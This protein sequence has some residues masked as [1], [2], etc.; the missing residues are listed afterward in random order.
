[1]SI[2]ATYIF[3]IASTVYGN[4]QGSYVYTIYNTKPL[5]PSQNLPASHVVIYS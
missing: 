2:L 1:M 3:H 4:F 5:Y